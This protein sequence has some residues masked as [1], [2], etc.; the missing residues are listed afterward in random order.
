MKARNGIEININGKTDP[1][2]GELSSLWETDADGNPLVD[3]KG[4][5]IPLSKE[6]DELRS[7]AGMLLVDDL[8]ARQSRGE[9]IPDGE[10]A[11]NPDNNTWSGQYLNDKQI[12]LL[13]LSGRFNSKQIK[14]LKMLNAAAKATSDPNAD[15]ATRGHRF[16]V[17]YQAALKKNK[18]GQW[19]YDQ[20]KPQ[21]RDIVPYGVEISKDGNVLYRIMSTNQLF[22]NASEKATSKRGRS[23]YQGNMESILRDANKVIDLHGKNEAT[24]AYFKSEY[25]KDIDRIIP[26]NENSSSSRVEVKTEFGSSLN[27]SDVKSSLDLSV[28]R[29]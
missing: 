9:S 27:L 26:V 8:R 24:D 22:A 17:M 4:E 13:S 12:E 16:S 11:Y 19:R 2:L 15:P 21:L 7:N 6:T 14:Q 1:I 25:P 10:L 5:Y 29:I 3:K 23:L 18:K 28:S 20:I